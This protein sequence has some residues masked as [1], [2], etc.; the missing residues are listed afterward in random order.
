MKQIVQGIIQYTIDNRGAMPAQGGGSVTWHDSSN[1]SAG[2]WDWIAWQRKVDPV[3][4]G[5][6]PSAAD[7]KITDSAVAKYLSKSADTLEALFRCPSDN[8]L[9]RPQTVADNNG[10]K[11]GYR[12]SYGANQFM[13][14]KKGNLKKITSIKD[15]G[16]KV[17]LVC[18]DEKTLDDGFFNPNP[19]QWEAGRCNLVAARHQI[20][21]P[22]ARNAGD[23]TQQNEEARGNVVF[24]D[25]HG[26]YFNRKDALRQRYTDNTYGDPDNF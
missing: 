23:M 1:P 15:P 16:N 5:S 21:I 4:G 3:T 12:Y 8:L 14:S 17:L 11:G 13:M 9:Q 24:V 6:N 19:T 10:G 18:E 25:G 22:G 20:Q 7:L 2:T 26:D